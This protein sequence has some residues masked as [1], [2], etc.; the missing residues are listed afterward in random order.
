MV[1]YTKILNYDEEKGELYVEGVNGSIQL[2]IIPD[3][4]CA[5]I[6]N[7]NINVV[8]LKDYSGKQISVKRGATIESAFADW[9]KAERINKDYIRSSHAS[10]ESLEPAIYA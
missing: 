1:T 4:I 10:N 2:D 7:P 9:L 6:Y 8:H 3:V 5:L